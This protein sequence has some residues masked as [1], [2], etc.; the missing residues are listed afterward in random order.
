MFFLSRQH[1]G[2]QPVLGPH[3][4]LKG[5]ALGLGGGATMYNERAS[6]R[7]EL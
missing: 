1:L 5:G 4:F 3:F 7:P 2:Y 6:V